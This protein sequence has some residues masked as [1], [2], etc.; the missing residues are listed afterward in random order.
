MKQTKKQHTTNTLKRKTAYGAWWKQHIYNLHLYSA[1]TSTVVSAEPQLTAAIVDEEMSTL[2]LHSCI[3]KI[4][5]NLSTSS[6]YFCILIF[7][8]LC[9]LFFILK[10]YT[11]NLKYLSMEVCDLGHT[12]PLIT[13]KKVIK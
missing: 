9:I 4:R 6:G 5:A 13:K 2:N 12:K 10:Q 7:H 1:V 8:I 11:Q 3:L